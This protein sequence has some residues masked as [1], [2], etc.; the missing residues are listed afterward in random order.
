MVK[1]VIIEVLLVPEAINKSSAKIESEILREFSEGFLLI[2]W[3]QK[4]ERLRV[5]E[6]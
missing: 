1:K 4:I 5:V 2:P 3:G 6:A